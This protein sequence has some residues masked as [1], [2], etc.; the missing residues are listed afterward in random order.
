MAAVC[1]AGTY[2]QV[3]WVIFDEKYFRPVIW[4]RAGIIPI[5]GL[6]DFWVRRTQVVEAHSRDLLNLVALHKRWGYRIF[7]IKLNSLIVETILEDLF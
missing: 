3:H 5:V 1:S 2:L 6:I 7:F 4:D